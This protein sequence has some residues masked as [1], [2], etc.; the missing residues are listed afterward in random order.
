EI[1]KLTRTGHIQRPAYNLVAEWVLRAWNQVNSPEAQNKNSEY[2]YIDEDN[3]SNSKSIVD[4]TQNDNGSE[5][6]DNNYNIED[7]SNEGDG[8]KDDSNKDDDDET[9]EGCDEDTY[10]DE[11]VV[12]YVNL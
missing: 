7:D 10:Y 5:N 4:L 3:A 2:V 11:W 8:D 12:E 6:N 1:K 9:D